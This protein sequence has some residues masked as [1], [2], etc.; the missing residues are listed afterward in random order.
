MINSNEPTSIFLEQ[1]TS[2]SLSY[3]I[4]QTNSGTGTNP[5]LGLNQ[6]TNSSQITGMQPQQVHLAYPNQNCQLNLNSQEVNAPHLYSNSSVIKIRGRNLSQH[7]TQKKILLPNKGI[8]EGLLNKNARQRFGSEES[9]Q[10]FAPNQIRNQLKSVD[11]SMGSHRSNNYQRLQHAPV[12]YTNRDLS[13]PKQE[14]DLSA[15]DFLMGSSQ[16]V[17]RSIISK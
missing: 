8:G 1:Q 17:H 7:S 10:N 16:M 5:P 13:R 12:P 9:I 6:L 14:K 15:R 2:G 3:N 4:S 11:K